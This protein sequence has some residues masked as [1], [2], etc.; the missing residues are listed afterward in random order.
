MVV[1]LAGVAGLNGCQR[2][3]AEENAE[4]ASEKASPVFSPQS[5]IDLIKTRPCESK[6][7][8]PVSMRTVAG[9]SSFVIAEGGK[10]RTP[11]VIPP[12]SLY[13]SQIAQLL[14]EHLEKATGAVFEIVH[15][16]PEGK[17]IYVGPFQSPE[18]APTL[19]KAKSLPPEH[20]LVESF[21]KGVMLIGND[22]DRAIDTGQELSIYNFN[23]AGA[24]LYCSRGT[25]F[26]A[27]DFLERFVGIRW[28]LPGPL[29]LCVPDLKDARL[30]MPPV[31]YEDG[32]VFSCR[33]SNN[34]DQL[35]NEKSAKKN[36]P[37]S[38][39]DWYIWSNIATRMG[40]MT[41][42]VAN[43]TDCFWHKYY[44][45]DHPEYFAL[46]A[47][48]SRMIGDEGKEIYSSQRCYTNEGGFQEHLKNI[49]RYLSAKKEDPEKFG[50]IDP[51]RIP[52]K[53]CIY[54]V[55]N[56]S[57]SGCACPECMKLTDKNAPT[58][59]IHSRLIWSYAAKLGRAIK[60]RW[61]EKKL[62]VLAYGTAGFIPPEIKL[63]DN[64][65][66][67]F[68]MN[69]V[70][71]C[72]MK[73]TKYRQANQERL[74]AIYNKT[75]SKVGLWIYYPACPSYQNKM[76]IPLFAPHVQV[77][78]FKANKNKIYGVF[79]CNA[80][81]ESIRVNGQ[82]LYLY[83]KQLWNPDMDVDAYLAEF[84]ALMYGPAALQ[85]KDYYQTTVDRWEN[86]KWSYLPPPYGLPLA[87]PESMIWKETYP[88]EVRDHLQKTLREA[89]AAAPDGS[90]YQARV[91][92]LID[93]TASFFEQGRFA[94]ETVKPLVDC[95]HLDQPPK[96][97]GDTREWDGRIPVI[98]KT[99][100]GAEAA[101]RTEIFTAHDSRN[102]YLAGRVHESQGMILPPDKSKKGDVFNHDSVEIFLCADQFGLAEAG[103]PKSEQYYQIALN[104]A[105]TAV[106]YRKEL[107]QLHGTPLDKLDFTCAV[108][109]MGKGFQFE[110]A[111]PFASLNAKVPV[112]G[113]SE[114]FVNFYR[115]RPRGEDKGYQAWTPTMGKP[116]FESSRFGI[117]RF[118]TTPLYEINF[119]KAA[120]SVQDWTTVPVPK[121]ASW[122]LK[123]GNLVVNVK[124]LP[125]LT[126]DATT[127]VY[128]DKIPKLPLDQPVKVEWGFRYKGVGLKAVGL[129][130]KSS[131]DPETQKR[132]VASKT[133]QIIPVANNTTSDWQRG[134]L[135]IPDGEIKLDDI[136]YWDLGLRFAP[137][138]DFTIE[139]DSIRVLTDESP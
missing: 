135:K 30:Q 124:A 48:G 4:R 35:S 104:A 130:V 40:V 134:A 80:S 127:S 31:A 81:R 17:A 97:D 53:S 67:S 108:K 49:E 3:V 21:D 22:H 94:D 44:A 115:N 101:E 51:M 123:N 33:S 100:M 126:T 76:S 9:L 118:S 120:I 112:A 24:M 23:V 18:T 83:H 96:I 102:I 59:R 116:F 10:A 103:M 27:V 114:W 107:Q 87:V 129:T 75:H 79:L 121:E 55:P 34:P 78:F 113:K 52:N 133:L 85:M 43:H 42:V 41:P 137:G 16:A 19:D 29:G 70:A 37:N 84:V 95:T 58:D 72:Y 25:L 36:E 128:F 92:Y 82:A 117:L 132:S 77:E 46:R 11:I 68:C 93:S 28:Y 39:E 62:C 110:M 105:G 64:V 122:R 65:V 54:W 73:E 26:A 74:D 5:Q 136:F 111:I 125:A 38:Q 20:F 47:D 63:P 14:K 61:P 13:Y 109:P 15:A 131:H 57:F 99:W 139:I 66:V 106:V 8:T 7:L 6:G 2:G 138:A 12:N 91:Q 56:D 119:E 60:E 69:D 88:R 71:D 45:K 32:P 89:L 50:G 90:I 86:T 1:G 98:L